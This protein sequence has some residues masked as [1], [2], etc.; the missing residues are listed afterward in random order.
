MPELPEVETVANQLAPLARGR[1]VARFELF[2]P[3]LQAMVAL[4]KAAVGRVIEDVRRVGKQVVI[5]F[6]HDGADGPHRP[7]WLAVHLRMTGRL[8]W[9]DDPLPNDESSPPSPLHPPPLK[10][11]AIL[12][13]DRGAIVFRDVRRFGTMRLID[14]PEDLAPGGIDPVG[15]DFTPAALAT[16]LAGSRVA[17]KPWL[18]RQDRLVGIGNIYA[19]EI[20]FDA[21]LSPLRPAGS[22]TRAEIARLHKSTLKI[23]R[24]G[25][26]CG[27]T[28]FSDFQDAHGA[29]GEFQ[30]MLK[31]Y[32]R[33]GEPCPRCRRPLE[34]L[35]QQ[36][37]STF[38]CAKCQPVR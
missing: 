7:L 38:H 33:G 9:L 10:A 6:A 8:V 29:A 19:S 31:V 23:L 22:L 34:R 20:L 5:V 13:L 27:G 25:I 11:R 17:L 37:R 24:W 36:N 1:R 18:L 14:R 3:K 2:D 16:L 26:E 28:T 35:S 30:K 15:P 4:P 32:G 21:R 12:T